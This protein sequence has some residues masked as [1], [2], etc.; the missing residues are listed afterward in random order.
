MAT[1]YITIKGYIKD[2]Q[3]IYDLP[4]NVTDGE[5]R[6]EVPVTGAEADASWEEQPWTEAELA[7]ALQFQP[8]PANEIETGGWDDIEDSENPRVNK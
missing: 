3:L 6:L 1:N 5:V 4:D 2:G 8:V 7:D